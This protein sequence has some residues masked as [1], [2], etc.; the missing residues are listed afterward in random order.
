MKMT[1][2]T[3]IQL[4]KDLKK[5]SRDNEA[6]IWAKLAQFATKPGSAK[7]IININRIS[8]LTKDNDTI[9]FPGKVLGIGT[10]SHKVTIFSFSISNTAAD[11]IIKAGGKIVSHR[12]I[13]EQYPT[14]RG[15]MLLG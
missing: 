10:I 15:V 14:G 1:G 9:V 6:P 2:Q 8:Q 11:K 12:H 5:A 3:V 13:T 7:R 4:V